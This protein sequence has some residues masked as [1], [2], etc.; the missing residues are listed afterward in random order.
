[1][2]Y[3]YSLE[4]AKSDRA[5]KIAAGSCSNSADFVA[6]V[7][8]AQRI[9]MKRGNWFGVTWLVR[10]CLRDACIVWPRYVG[11]VIGLRFC[12]GDAAVLRNQYYAITGPGST[13]GWGYSNGWYGDVFV[14]DNGTVPCYNEVMACDAGRLIRYVV[15]K[16]PDLGKTCK[17]FGTQ[18]GGQPLQERGADGNWTDGITLTAADP[19]ASTSVYVTSITSVV[20]EATQGM[21]WLY[22]YDPP[23]DTLRDLAAFDPNE[24]H[25]RRRRSKVINWNAAPGCRQTDGSCVK[26]VEALVKLEFVPATNDNDFLMVD[27]FDALALAIRAIRRGEADEDAG[28]ESGLLLAVKELNLRER[29]RLPNDQTSVSVQVVGD[30]TLTNP[31]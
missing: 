22:E 23:N 11:T 24:T 12:N 8:Q 18:Y 15:T 6:L 29:D 28:R 21:A 5:I 30:Y 16:R 19:F 31:N 9:L 7:N 1:M 4:T 3:Q 20:R 17:I 26:Q 2:A 10:F 25:P 27:D 13:V 14:R